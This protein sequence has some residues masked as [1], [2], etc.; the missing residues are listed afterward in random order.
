VWYTVF[1]DASSVLERAIGEIAALDVDALTDDEL[2][3]QLVAL[4]RMADR[5]TAVI[6]PLARRWDARQVWADDGSKSASARLARECGASQRSTAALLRRARALGSMSETSA[7]A[8]T[9]VISIDQVDL[10]AN[11]NT[12]RRRA[13]FVE[14]ERALVDA[15]A[16]LRYEPAKRSVRYWCL[17]A[18]AELERNGGG[19]ESPD[20]CEKNR[21]HASRTIDGTVV[22]DGVLDAISGSIVT[23]E[24]RRLIAEVRD[25]GDERTLPQLRAAA[26]VEMARRS[27]ARSGDVPRAK[28]LLTVLVGDRTVE[29][30]CELANGTVISPKQLVPWLTDALMETVLF[31]GPST[32]MSVSRKR[33]FT[34]AVRRAI[35]ARDRHCQHPSGCDEPV[36]ECDADHIVP[37]AQGGVT[38]QFNGRLQCK[39]H[40]RNHRRHDHGA[41]PFPHR[42][43]DRLEEWRARMKWRF[44][45]DP[46]D[47]ESG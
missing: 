21:L 14:R 9:G 42:P 6:A 41:A 44:H 15:I 17:R 1:V 29:H 37:Y 16:P 35:E 46:P 13:M 31:D 7:A 40:N 45:R 47:A 28:P 22:I 39:P 8:V 3:E 38:S 33:S 26:L 23:D 27:A 18:D 10:L 30:L 20:P 12:A 19:D 4:Q 2:H 43:I 32:V 5:L 11:A 24:L 25:E 34:G 36:D